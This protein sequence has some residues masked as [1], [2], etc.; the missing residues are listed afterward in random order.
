MKSLLTLFTAFLLVTVVFTAPAQ[1]QRTPVRP[2]AQKVKQPRAFKKHYQQRLER[3]MRARPRAL[4][5][6][7]RSTNP[8]FYSPRAA[9]GYAR[10][11]NRNARLRTRANVSPRTLARSNRAQ[12][13]VK[14]I[15]RQQKRQIRRSTARPS[16]AKPT[17]WK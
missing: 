17:F 1:A 9:S 4:K 3:R 16:R 2:Q 7:V 12:A 11:V 14:R 6:N 10:R 5:T 15:K 13:T 8:R